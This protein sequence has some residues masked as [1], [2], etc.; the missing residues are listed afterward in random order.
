VSQTVWLPRWY[1]CSGFAITS[2]ARVIDSTPPATKRSPSLA[3]TACEA[4]TTADIVLARL[5]R[6]AEVDVLDLGGVDPGSRDGLLDH[7]RRQV[8]RP[9]TGQRARVAPDRS[10]DG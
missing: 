4:E 7:E 5:V 6:G 9:L 3:T 2:G 1:A 8:V 10:P